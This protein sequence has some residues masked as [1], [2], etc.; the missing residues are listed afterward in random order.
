MERQDQSGSSGYEEDPLFVELTLLETEAVKMIQSGS[1]SSEEMCELE[2][3][4]ASWQ[5][6]LRECERRKALMSGYATIRFHW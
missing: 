1:I 6:D 2:T 3:R 5:I 4:L